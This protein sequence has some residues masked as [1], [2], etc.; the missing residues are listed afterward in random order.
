MPI[1]GIK[2]NFN[3]FFSDFATVFT[4]KLDMYLSTKYM[5]NR[6]LPGGIWEIYNTFNFKKVQKLDSFRVKLVNFLL[7]R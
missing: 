7:K 6:L 3:G 5:L 1:C 4:K 2:Q